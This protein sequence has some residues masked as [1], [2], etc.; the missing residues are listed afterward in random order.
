MLTFTKKKLA[1]VAAA[2]LMM[3]GCSSNQAAPEPAAADQAQQT[4]KIGYPNIL[5]M[6]P[7]II[8]EKQKLMEEQG[9]HAE[10]YQFANG[11]DLNKALSSGK[12]D[13][14]YTGIPVVVNWAS[15]GADISVIA[16]VGEGEFGLLTKGDAEITGP[17]DLK[18]KK[19]GFLGK[20]TGS[21]ILVRGF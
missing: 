1:A 13:V 8:A 16:K 3:G 11:P 2:V 21:D 18:G 12:L 9:L 6:A 7:A 17:L 15:R 20:G 19:V 4:I 10:F 5:S 14:A